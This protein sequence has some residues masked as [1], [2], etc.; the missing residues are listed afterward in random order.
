VRSDWAGKL[1]VLFAVLLAASC[2][3]PPPPEPDAGPPQSKSRLPPDKTVLEDV[4][5]YA[6][7]LFTFEDLQHRAVASFGRGKFEAYCEE[8]HALDLSMDRLPA[9][10]DEFEKR[11]RDSKRKVARDNCFQEHVRGASR[12]LPVAARVRTAVVGLDDYDFDRQVFRLK[13]RGG[14]GGH[15]PDYFLLPVNDASCSFESMTYVANRGYLVLR[16]TSSNNIAH[17]EGNQLVVKLHI[18]EARAKSTKAQLT[19]QIQKGVVTVETAFEFESDSIEETPLTCVVAT[20]KGLMGRAIGYR[21]LN[22]Q[23]ELQPWTPM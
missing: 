21:I 9:A 7:D 13:T 5:H 18:P 8:E 2:S 3:K 10:K 16:L 14:W 15:S 22:D 12:P 19:S 23:D 17:G 1:A 20:L 11:E 6:P 4:L